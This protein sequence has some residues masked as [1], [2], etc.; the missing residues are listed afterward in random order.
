MS[1]ERKQTT[2]HFH[3]TDTEALLLLK[4]TVSIFLGEYT[5]THTVTHIRK[6]KVSTKPDS[7]R[8]LTA[9][10]ATMRLQ[11]MSPDESMHPV[12]E[13]EARRDVE[14]PHTLGTDRRNFT[15]GTKWRALGASRVEG[16]LFCL[17]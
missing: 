11:R 2:A 3:R 6:S 4:S 15:P 14:H 12:F 8:L 13:P 1:T 7:D 17:P 16:A 9:K 10:I 5:D